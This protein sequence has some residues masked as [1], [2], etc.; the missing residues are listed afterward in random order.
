M[1]NK[2]VEILFTSEYS[3]GKNMLTGAELERLNSLCAAPIRG[4]Q[5]TEAHRKKD[6]PYLGK[7]ENDWPE[8]RELLDYYYI[9][10]RSAVLPLNQFLAIG[11]PNV[12]YK[13]TGTI[14]DIPEYHIE[15]S[16]LHQLTKISKQLEG[17]NALQQFNYK[18]GVHISDL[19]LLGVRFV[20][21]LVDECTDELQG[22]L[23]DGWRILA[24]CPQPNS[25]RPDYIIGRNNKED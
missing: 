12:Y 23:D 14:K 24:V 3:F 5:M 13:I 22:Y 10:G 7:A 11:L 19:G 16:L 18:V 25:R 20:K 6:N 21:V 9:G 1:T 15:D 2:L 17:F 8:A 4:E